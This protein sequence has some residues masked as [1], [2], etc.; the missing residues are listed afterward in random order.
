[1][2]EPAF[3]VS[4]CAAPRGEGYTGVLDQT[5]DL[6]TGRW[7]NRLAAW[8]G[9]RRR[10]RAILPELAAAGVIEVTYERRGEAP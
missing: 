9:L 6:N 1:M 10:I 4:I 7:P 2:P 5:G 3:T 8:L